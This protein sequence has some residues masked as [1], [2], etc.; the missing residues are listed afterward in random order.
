MSKTDNAPITPPPI[1]DLPLRVFHW[2][3]MLAVIGAIASAKNDAM[4]WHEKCGL[5]V[6]GLV[7]FRIIWGFC[8]TYH[9]RFSQFMVSPN[10]LIIYIKARFNGDRKP[11]LGHS[12]MGAYA[13]VF[14]LAVLLVMAG[15]GT[16]SNDDIFYDA[17]LA[18]FVGYFSD[19]ASDLHHLVEKL[20]FFAIAS[21][22]LALLFYRYVLKIKLVRAMVSGGGGGVS[23]THQGLGFALMAMA[24]LAAHSL[25]F[26]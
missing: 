10:Q 23:K 24:L 3:L 5:T 6:L 1:W 17:P 25:S 9:A 14:I 22:L 8:G 20:V 7:V 26:L 16:M 19:R 4:Y 21:H 18:A 11:I 2:G 13:T 12:P 15:L